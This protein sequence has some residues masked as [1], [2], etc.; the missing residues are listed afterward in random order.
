MSRFPVAVAVVF[1]GCSASGGAS[2]ERAPSHERAAAPSAEPAGIAGAPDSGGGGESDGSL[3]GAAAAGG[4][5]ATAGAGG[6]PLASAGGGATGSAGAAPE[7]GGHAPTSGSSGSA[8][9]AGTGTVGGGPSPD[10]RSDDCQRPGWRFEC[11]APPADYP[12]CHCIVSAT[13]CWGTSPGA[14][15]DGEHCWAYSIKKQGV[16]IHGVPA[17][18]L[19]ELNADTINCAE[20]DAALAA[21]CGCD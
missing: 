19:C 3:A 16:A 15:S 14:G 1:L 17:G 21:E 9:L 2:V 10:G 7:Q 4:G 18:L 5:T 20:A 13:T 12:I 6:V 8:G 11:P